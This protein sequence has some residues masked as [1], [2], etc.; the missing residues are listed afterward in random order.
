MDC[1]HWCSRSSH[2]LHTGYWRSSEHSSSQCVQKT[3]ENKAPDLM[4]SSDDIHWR[5]STC[6]WKESLSLMRICARGYPMQNMFNGLL[7]GNKSARLTVT[8]K[9]QV[10]DNFSLFN[11]ASPSACRWS[12]AVLGSQRWLQLKLHNLVHMWFRVKMEQHTAETEAC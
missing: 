3:E 1:S 7:Q 5:A 12:E 2:H 11:R 9:E 8:T 6:R 4:C 10:H